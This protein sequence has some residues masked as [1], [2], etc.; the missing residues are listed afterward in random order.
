MKS[1]KSIEF[2]K[3]GNEKQYAFNEDLDR[4]LDR[5]QEELDGAKEGGSPIRR[6]KEAITAGR[7]ALTSCQKLIL[8]ADRSEF[9]LDVAKKNEADKLAEDSKMR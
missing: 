1:S 4:H 9:G 2:R 3:K 5:A 6:A 7:R 8:L